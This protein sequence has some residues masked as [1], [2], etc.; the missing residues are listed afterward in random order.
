[1]K[2]L[3]ATHETQNDRPGDFAWV[4]EGEIVT[5][6]AYGMCDSYRH[7]GA[8]GLSTCGCDRSFTGIVSGSSSTTAKIVER[9]DITRDDIVDQLTKRLMEAFDAT[10]AEM[11]P[12]AVEEVN[13]MLDV[14]NDLTLGRV[15]GMNVEKFFVR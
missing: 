10:D 8:D 6:G 4:E 3:V 11:R 13:E 14:A 15:V 5:A 7:A 9:D 1:M 12:V 2:I